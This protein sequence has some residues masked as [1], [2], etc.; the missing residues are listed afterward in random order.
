MKCRA[1]LFLLAGLGALFVSRGAAASPDPAQ[2]RQLLTV[3]TS[4]A[5][6][7]E[8]ARALQQ[9]ALVATPDAVPALAAL[10]GDEQLGQ[11]AR[12]G[13]ELIPG[14]AAAAALRA[15]LGTL[16]GNALVGVVNSLGLKRDPGAVE[17]LRRLGTE[18]GA[19]AAPAALLAL[20]RIGTPEATRALEQVLSG[21]PAELRPA[22]AESLILCADRALQDGLPAVARTWLTAVRQ[23]DVPAP[24]R[25]T[26]T[27]GLILAGGPEGRALLLEQ[28]R[29]GK[30]EQVG[31]ALRTLRDLPDAGTTSALVGALDGLEPPLQP[32]VLR[33][34]VDRGGDGVLPAVESRAATG[35]GEIQVEALHGLGRIGR[36][37]SVPI[38][39]NVVRTS[40]SDAA[41]SAALAALARIEAADTAARILALLPAVEPAL[42]VR[43]IAVL[44]ER[45][46]V[47]A[48]GE[49]LRLAGGTDAAVAQAAWRALGLSA[50]PADL[51]SLIRLAVTARDDAERT[52]ADRAIVT[53]AMKLLEPGR[54]ADAVL[55]AFRA[56]TDPVEK[57]A[58]L[59]PLGA[60]LR[61][62]G[63]SH[64]AFFAVRESLKDQAAGVRDAAVSCLAD[65]PDASPTTTLLEL[66]LKPAT[67]P[68]QREIALRGAV[69]LATAVAAGRERSPLNAHAVLVQANQA[70]RTDAEKM[71]IVSALGSLR[72]PEA[73]TMLRPYLDDP[74][75]QTEAR[76]ALVQVAQALGGAK[77]PGE[78]R[79]LLEQIAVK[80]ADEDVRR[81]AARLAKGAPVVAAKTKAG[82]G[83]AAPAAKSTSGLF[84][85]TD[86]V[87]WNGDPGVW[88]VRDGSIVGG[89]ML[90]NPRNEFLAFG[91]T[92]KNF[93]VRLEYRIVGT[94]GFINGGVQVRS[95]RIA[96][97]PNEMSGYQADIGAGHSGCL[98][99]ESR[100]KKFLARGTEEQ[101]KRLEKPGEWN[102]YEIRC[103]GPRVEI[104][105]NGERTV[106]YTE[107]D[108]SVAAEGLL[109]LQIHGNC[110][111]EIA[112]RN[113]HLEELQ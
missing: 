80:D 58:L 42:R 94:E 36:A 67:P 35:T 44:G 8:R 81:R 15:A 23:A 111:A 96:Q 63:G 32:L 73:V 51:P 113:L 16:Q 83:T 87:G 106:A 88:R 98:Y 71:M 75:V 49:L 74:A 18:R 39:L 10:L 65:W 91:R 93:V 24:L 59:R 64:E 46:A 2:T 77:E 69:R 70:V 40:S 54:R 110:K 62:M 50:T 82:A 4:A 99:D 43:L 30:S 61:T 3:V 66:A 9:L 84:N 85:G 79:R 34:L 57:A 17:A 28:L 68:A 13:L 45:K 14:E 60:I 72:H 55:S 41:V 53:T 89:S 56:A 101:I 105:L 19:V 97:P 108:A 90:G 103:D 86:L 102:R 37:S 29:S 76:L 5:P 112:F 100:R 31:M 26:A 7:A 21:G 25:L 22:A 109:A 12:D 1:S 20:G 11:Y 92:L 6:V 95:V 107:D 104:S 27:R 33:A 48:N 38:L 52:L 47:E 78:L